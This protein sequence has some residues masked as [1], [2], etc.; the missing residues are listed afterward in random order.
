VNHIIYK[1]TS[2]SG[3]SYIG[4]TKN[5]SDR[6][7]NHRKKTTCPAIAAAIKKYGWESFQ[8]EILL[9][10]LSLEEANYWEAWYIKE[11]RTLSPNGYNLMTGGGNSSPSAETRAKLSLAKKNQSKETKEK[12]SK[13]HMGKVVSAETRARI[14]AA[15]KLRAPISET[16]R[17]KLSIASK[18][19]AKSSR[20]SAAQKHIGLKMSEECKAKMS[21][22]KKNQSPETRMK[23]SM[24]H[25]GKKKSPES[26]AKRTAT[27]RANNL[28]GRY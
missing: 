27:R 15:A 21:E 19:M 4:Q 2:P 17:L 13:S 6:N 22:I 8:H 10:G 18:G 26:I 3:K 28:D 12:I 11:H 1:H 20:Q 9:S 16:T 25:I 14:S 24:A 7:S 5:L 23:I